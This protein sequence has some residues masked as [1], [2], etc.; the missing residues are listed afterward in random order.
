MAILLVILLVG[1]GLI[2]LGF[3]LA[4]PA[5]RGSTSALVGWL[6]ILAAEI[7]VVGGAASRAFWEVT[8]ISGAIVLAQAGLFEMARRNARA[9]ASEPES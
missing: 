1:L 6:L 3:V 5:G 2:T 7:S 8:L 4:R 9:G